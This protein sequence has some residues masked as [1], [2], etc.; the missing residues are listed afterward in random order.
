MEGLKGSDLLTAVSRNPEIN[1][2]YERHN[3][4]EG[5]ILSLF[6]LRL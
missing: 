4:R 6:W 1:D 3:T 2:E 5:I